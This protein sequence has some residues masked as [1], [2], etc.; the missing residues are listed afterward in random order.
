MC[1]YQ[2]G[3]LPVPSLVQFDDDVELTGFPDFYKRVK[4]VSTSFIC[5]TSSCVPQSETTNHWT[6]WSGKSDLD[7]SGF[8]L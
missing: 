4:A 7:S 3:F 6:Q 2:L 1:M 8:N 5:Q